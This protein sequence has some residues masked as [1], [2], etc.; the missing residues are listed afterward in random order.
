MLYCIDSLPPTGGFP[1][2]Q[3]AGLLERLDRTRFAPHVCTLVPEQPLRTLPADVPHLSL[4]V[5]KL[6]GPE[7]WRASRQLARY[8]RRHRIAIVQT[9]FQDATV[10]GL[11]SARLAGVPVRL[12]SFRDLGFWRQ[13]RIEFL[14]RR[15][16]PLATAFVV[17]STAVRDHFLAV[18]R[19]PAGRF[20]VIP[21]GLDVA[22][23]PFEPR[24]DEPPRIV[25]VGNLN[26]R[27]KRADL[28]IAACREAADRCGR[29]RWQLVGDGQLR[30]EYEALAREL[31]VAGRLEFLGRRTDI[32]DILAGAAVGVNCS[33]SEGFSNAVL[34]CMLAGCAVVATDVGGNREL[35]VP[36]EDGLLVPVDDAPA[37]G[38]AVARL[39]N[40]PELAARLAR[41]ARSRAEQEF[42][43]E[44]SVA[45]HQE[46]Y[47]RLLAEHRR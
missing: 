33:D 42:S 2:Q 17:N 28:F 9:F 13:P 22:A 40:E 3:L 11:W 4:A 27:V 31:G 39:V 34:E 38:A 36:D 45:R 5:R 8:V 32:A 41:H 24:R 16:Y 25:Q 7:A 14:M 19:L 37:L 21:N 12:A 35:I 47:A 23:F 6:L 26:R 46:L 29:A 43:W 30:T 18:D 10:F 15:S 20:H 1:G 44:A